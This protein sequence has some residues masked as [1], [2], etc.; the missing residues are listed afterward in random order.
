LITTFF[1]SSGQWL[2]GVIELV[3]EK[4]NAQG[5]CGAITYMRRNSIVT[6]LN[7]MTEVDT[8]GNDAC[9]KP[10]KKENKEESDP[11]EDFIKRRKVVP[12]TPIYDFIMEKSKASGK[13]FRDIIA[14]AAKSKNNEEKLMAVFAEVTV[15]KAPKV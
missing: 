7:L 8:D 9:S 3:N 6:M 1:H 12:N 2:R 13:T 10:A 5:L 15:S 14:Y 11:V 4:N